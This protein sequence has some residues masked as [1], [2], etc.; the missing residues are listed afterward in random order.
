MRIGVSRRNSCVDLFKF[1]KVAL[2]SQERWSQAMEE[3]RS[4]ISVL[5]LLHVLD[6]L[7]EFLSELFTLRFVALVVE[8]GA[9]V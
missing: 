1:V 4:I 7:E 9:A 2:F 8:K 6:D 5:L 3:D